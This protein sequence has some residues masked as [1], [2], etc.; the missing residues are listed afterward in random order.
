MALRAM[1]AHRMRTFLTMLGIII[2]IASVVSVVALGTGARQAILQHFLA[3]HQHHRDLSRV[4]LRRPALD[5]GGNAHPGDSVALAGSRSWTA[6]HRRGHHRHRAARQPL[7]QRAGAGRQR[8]VLPRAWPAAGRRCFFGPAAVAGQQVVVI[9][10]NTRARF[11]AAVDNPIG[12]TLL[13]GNVPVRVVGVVK[14]RCGRRCLLRC[15]C[16]TTTMARMLG[17]SHVSS[18]TVRVSDAISMEAAERAIGRLLARRHGSTD[19]SHEQQRADPPVH[20]TDHRHPDHDDQLHRRHRAGSGRNRSDEHHA[21]VGD[22][23]NTRDRR[24]H[25]GGARRSDIP[26]QFL[27]ESVLVCLLGGVLGIGV[28][29]ALGQGWRWPTWVS[30]LCSPPIRSWPPSP[31]P[32]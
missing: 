11:F 5:A 12:Q 25:G 1:N 13:L 28:A 31:V 32:A 14:G 26:Q 15:G 21:G 8:A 19:F 18:I 9:D 24:A 16:P 3:G 22:R 10:A 29:L 2:G 6:L 4:R 20:R 17:Q 30:A 23:A 27:I 7:G